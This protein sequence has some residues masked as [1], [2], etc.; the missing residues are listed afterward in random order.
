M[1]TVNLLVY[2][3]YSVDF[4]IVVLYCIAMQFNSIQF[5]CICIAL[6]HKTVSKGFTGQ[7]IMGQT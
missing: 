2:L 5:N 7:I 1:A 3:Y 4:T 6:N